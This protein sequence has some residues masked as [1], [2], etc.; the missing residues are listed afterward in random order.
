[1]WLVSFG[2]RLSVGGIAFMVF[3]QIKVRS[4]PRHHFFYSCYQLFK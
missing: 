3:I 1:M 2:F 4:V